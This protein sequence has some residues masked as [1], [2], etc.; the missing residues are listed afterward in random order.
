MPLS[1]PTLTLL[2]C[3]KDSAR[4]AKV[5]KVLGQRVESAIEGEM[6]IVVVKN[7]LRSKRTPSSRKKARRK[8]AA[9]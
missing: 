3:R 5:L 4:M 6:L 1:K 2:R 9:R 8:T 7:P